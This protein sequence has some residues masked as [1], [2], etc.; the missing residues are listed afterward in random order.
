MDSRS[1]AHVLSQIGALLELKGDQKFK[2]RAYAGAARALV[3]LDTDDLGPL[4][5]SGE[6]AEVPGVG[7]ATLSV[8]RELVETGESSYLDELREGIPEGL[9]E[10]LRVPGLGA[11]KVQLIHA[12]LGVES[13]ED[14]ERVAQN[15][16]LASLPR[17]GK[18]TAEKILKGIEILRRDAHLKR[19]PAAAIEAH[20]LLAN[21]V[22][23][24]DIT[25][26]DVAGAI[27]RHCE[28]VAGIEIV[29][30]CS[31]DPARVAASFARS[32]GVRESK[33]R[34]DPGSVHIRF[35]DG[36]HLDM[37]CV[38]KGDY[39]VALWRA[40]GSAAH[41][42]ELT[43]LAR[44]KG[45]EITRNSLIRKGAERV[46]LA[47]EES[48]FTALDLEPIP[49]EMR[50][51][52]GEI[53]A[54]A[55]RELPNL[56]T[57]D[58][59]RGVLH[60]HSDYSDGAATIEAMAL[61]A[62]E[63]G[64]DYI[65]ISDHSESAFYAGGLKRDRLF[66]QQEEIDELN[67]RMDGF[68]ILKGIEADI[69]A[70]GRLDYDAEILDGFDYVVGSIHSR[71]SMDGD[72]MTKRV[73]AAMDDPHLTILA[74]PTGRL[75]LTREPYPINIQAVLEKAVQVGVAVELNADPHRLDLDWRYCRQAKELGVTIEIGPD[76]HSTAALDNVHFGIGMA[77]KAWLEAGEILNA[78]GADDVVAFARKRRTT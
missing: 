17:F 45:F 14:L 28:L 40:T 30:E 34:E 77:R 39:P 10:L 2:A 22:K 74:H 59:I 1:A 58:D 9:L 36:T 20:L 21:I 43:E 13:L 70:D 41:V 24:P 23:H 63:R 46:D 25:H 12:T 47:D 16:Q 55:R 5:R 32:P 26:A 8:V 54:A 66:R 3:A 18:K 35:V 37:H 11:A 65:G 42:E 7:P 31:T 72:A 68:R 69:L 53:E 19:F 52:M 49:P 4:L 76:A 15:G 29:A 48:L 61:A 71:F 27:R 67:S 60:C 56:V 33:T 57:F 6:L 51:G 38:G 78:R 75:L 62:K 73:L 64:W 50:E 44:K